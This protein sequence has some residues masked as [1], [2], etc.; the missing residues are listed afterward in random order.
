MK[1]AKV[2]LPSGRECVAVVERDEVVPLTF[3][4][5]H[6]ESLTDL[7]ESP[8]PASNVGLLLDRTA[9]VALDQTTLL[10][11]IDRQEVWAAGVTYKR[12]RTAR[13]EESEGAAVFYDK[14][15][16]APRP[17]LFFKAT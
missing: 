17:E 8:D 15:Y 14:V 4:A 9:R 10:A 7:L 13:M 6:F 3:E 2:K 16:E 11:P 5:G 1:L 12:S